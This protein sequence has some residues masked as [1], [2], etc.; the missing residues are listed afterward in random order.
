MDAM[1]IHCGCDVA[2]LNVDVATLIKILSEFAQ[3]C[4]IRVTMS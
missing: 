3:C 1:P 2:T 4:D